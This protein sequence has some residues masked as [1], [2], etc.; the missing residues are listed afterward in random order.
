M[1]DIRLLQSGDRRLLES[2]SNFLL[3]GSLPGAIARACVAAFRTTGPSPIVAHSL[4]TA[5][6]EKVVRPPG[7]FQ[8]LYLPGG[9]GNELSWAVGGTTTNPQETNAVVRDLTDRLSYHRRGLSIPTDWTWGDSEMVD[10]IDTM[11]AYAETAYDFSPPYHLV[12]VSM[13]TPCAL[14]WAVNN[15][16]RVR[17]I[18]CML[19]AV[20]LQDIDTNRAPAYPAVVPPSDAQAYG[21]HSI[22]SAYNPATYA[23]DLS[24]IPI[25]LWYSNNDTICNPA[26][27]TAFASASGATAVNIGNQSVVGIVGHALDTGFTVADVGD[28]LLAS[29]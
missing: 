25:K 28:F 14:N 12:A 18:S 1:T 5:R 8:F 2:A 9:N 27:V 29:D 24:D 6:L 4:I 7:R 10:R 11:L 21:T 26:T 17:S 22:P 13:G 15:L 3:E 20:D 23:A 16:E 19:P